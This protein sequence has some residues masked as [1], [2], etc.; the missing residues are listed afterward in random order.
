MQLFSELIVSLSLSLAHRPSKRWISIPSSIAPAKRPRSSRVSEKQIKVP[1]AR[2]NHR[3]TQTELS[4]P[5]GLFQRGRGN[6]IVIRAEH[7]ISAVGSVLRART[8]IQKQTDLSSALRVNSGCLFRK[9]CMQ[10]ETSHH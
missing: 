7:K 8:Q 9:H 10:I 2:H 3:T 6:L 5:S 1:A 4:Y